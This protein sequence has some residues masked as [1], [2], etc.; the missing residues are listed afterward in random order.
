MR[1]KEISYSPWRGIPRHNKYL[2]H[3]GSFILCSTEPLGCCQQDAAVPE[4]IAQREWKLLAAQKSDD[5][6]W[7]RL[8]IATTVIA[9]DGTLTVH[10]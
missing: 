2:V 9:G 10:A 5:S 7:G 1:P 6:R 4:G 8:V 3:E